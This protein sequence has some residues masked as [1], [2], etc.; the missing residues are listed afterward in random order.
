MS[1]EPR[2]VI[3]RYPMNNLTR[4]FYVNDRIASET[5]VD[6]ISGADYLAKFQ[7]EKH[8]PATVQTAL[9]FYDIEG[10]T[11]VGLSI[12]EVRVT[13]SLAFDWEDVNPQVIDLIKKHLHW[14]DCE[15]RDH[16][17]L[18]SY[19]RDRSIVSDVPNDGNPED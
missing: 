10:V 6:T 9:S 1:R 15:V 5:L 12:Y 2:I 17:S 18:P 11:S 7:V 13:I 14:D 4:V 19:E 16:V 3:D 8:S